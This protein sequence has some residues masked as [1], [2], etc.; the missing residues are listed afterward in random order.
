MTATRQPDRPRYAW[1]ESPADI[2]LRFVGFA[3]KLA[4]RSV[5]HTGWYTDDDGVGGTFRGV[6]YRLPRKRGFI[7]GYAD[8]HNDGPAFVELSPIDHDD[9]IGAAHAAD[10]IA[11][12]EAEKEREYHRVWQAG[13]RFRDLGDTIA[14]ARRACL[15]LIREG[16]AARSTLADFAALSAAVRERAESYCRDIRKARE[17]RERLVSDYGHEAA[18]ND[19]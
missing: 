10:R 14:D 11:E 13:Q 16:K 7:A 2:G 17:E 1:V 8:P 19:A 3:D 5:R 15:A 4:P 9:V 18:F 6:V 12:M